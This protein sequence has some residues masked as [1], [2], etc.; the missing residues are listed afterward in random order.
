MHFAVAIALA[1]CIVAALYICTL[2]MRHLTSTADIRLQ[3]FRS[4][5]GQ[6][7]RPMA[8]IVNFYAQDITGCSCARSPPALIVTCAQWPSSMVYSVT[9]VGWLPS[10]DACAVP[11]GARVGALTHVF[12]V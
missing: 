12:N 9:I 10:R 1:L 8:L 5:E 2:I 3:M 11:T 4:G 6:P 7:R